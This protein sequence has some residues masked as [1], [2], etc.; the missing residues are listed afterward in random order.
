MRWSGLKLMKE[1]INGRNNFLDLGY[2]FIK[3]Y[4]G[5]GYATETAIASVFYAWDVLNARELCGIA[6]IDNIASRKVLQSAG[7][8]FIQNFD[9]NGDPY[10]WYE[11]KKVNTQ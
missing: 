4:W 10:E 2:R 1:T 7:L 9:F 3:Q 11:A 5:K 8:R 6:Q